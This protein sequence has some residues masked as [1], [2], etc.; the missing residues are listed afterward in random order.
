MK[1]CYTCNKVREISTSSEGIT[2]VNGKIYWHLDEKNLSQDLNKFQI[3]FGIE[4]AFKD[5]QKFINPTFSSTNDIEQ[6][7]IVFRFMSNGSEDLPFEFESDTLAYAFF[8]EGESLGIHS[9]IYMNDFFNWGIMHTESGY[10][11]YKVVVHEI[12]HALG[13]DHS[14]NDIDI[15]FPSYQPNDSVKITQDTIDGLTRLYGKVENDIHSHNCEDEV[16]KFISTVFQNKAELSKLY[17]RDL[18]QIANY[19]GIEAKEKDKKSETV[20]LILQKLTQ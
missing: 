9:D 10:N 8:P 5:W 11:M 4:N 17:E 16:L 18:V 1:D 7:A 3:I 14:E 13:L 2:P 12:G 19:I 6:A 15:M 20:N